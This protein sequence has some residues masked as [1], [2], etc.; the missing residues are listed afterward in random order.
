MFDWVSNI[1]GYSGTNFDEVY[2][3]ISGF[4]VVMTFVVSMDILINGLFSFFRRGK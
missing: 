2:I 4:L 1:I 3:Y